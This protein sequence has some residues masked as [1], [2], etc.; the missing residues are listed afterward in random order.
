MPFPLSKRI[1]KIRS[2]AAKLLDRKSAPAS[3]RG[4]A[5]AVP[6]DFQMSVEKRRFSYLFTTG[7]MS[8]AKGSYS[9][10]SAACNA[11]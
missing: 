2:V 11:A 7:L 4:V 3:H 8:V 10:P 5:T 6:Y 9:P 1:V